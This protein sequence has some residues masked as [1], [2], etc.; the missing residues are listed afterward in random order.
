MTVTAA[1]AAE[2][3][4]TLDAEFFFAEHANVPMHIGSVAVFDGPAPSREDLMRL[5][6]AKLPRVPRYRQVVRAAPLQLLRPV[7]ADD[8]EF[9]IRHH[10]RHAHVP[11]PGGPDQLRTV[12]SRLFAMPLDR[13]RP[14]WEGWLLD[15]LEG[16]RWAILSKIHHCMADGIG[17][18][19]LMAQIFSTDPAEPLPE[20]TRWDPAPPP[21]LA[22]LATDDLRDAMTWPIRGLAAAPGLLRRVAADDLR[23]YGHG[24]G[25]LVRDLTEPSADSLNG[26]IGPRRRW[27][28]TTAELAELKRIRAARGTTVNDVVLAAVTRAF[29]DLLDERGEL[30]ERMVVRSLVPVS[31]RGP[32]EDGAITN[33]V[34]AVLANLPVGEPDPLQRLRL[35]QREMDGLKH[36]HQA[37]GAEALTGLL[38]LVLGVAPAWLALGTRVAYQTP[39][40]LV[41]TVTTNVPGPRQPLYVL[42]R[43]LTALHPY[44]PIGNAVRVS[45]AILSYVNTISFGVT[46]DYDSS[47]DLDFFTLGIQ[48]G[49][50]EL[51]G[52]PARVAS[53]PER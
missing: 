12:A 17:G 15:G 29:R 2:R 7:W 41:Q 42:G 27:A 48:R 45:V 20:V 37:A 49:L 19:D 11:A 8:Q 51:T 25:Q 22:E 34:S 21:S 31:V 53:R 33:R 9:S 30:T 35:L 4:S 14:L 38:G 28:W 16:G 5:L 44:V 6:E 26:P 40:L 24:L 39:Q 50:A 52:P 47:P 23:S 13:H 36:T 43:R 1:A 10:I 32:G 3:M 46:A 18:N